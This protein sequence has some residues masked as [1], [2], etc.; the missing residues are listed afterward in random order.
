M[1]L[2]YI[3]SLCPYYILLHYYVLIIYYFIIQEF[4]PKGN[5]FEYL[6]NP[7]V[8]LDEHTRLKMAKDIALGMVYLHQRKPPIIHKDL[9]SLNILVDELSRLKICDFGMQAHARTSYVHTLSTIHTA[10]TFTHKHP[11]YS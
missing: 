10:H 4:M 6:A 7:A 11:I 1:N 3:T 5:L 8:L 9:K 2:L